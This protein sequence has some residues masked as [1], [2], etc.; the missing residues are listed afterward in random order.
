MQYA[1]TLKS[2]LSLSSIAITHSSS[3][4]SLQRLCLLSFITVHV[5]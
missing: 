2:T 1:I 3:I 4:K 5:S